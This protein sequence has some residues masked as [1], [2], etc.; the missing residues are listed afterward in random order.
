MRVEAVPSLRV[1][2]SWGRPRRQGPKGRTV[3]SACD[4]MITSVSA[5]N[6]LLEYSAIRELRVVLRCLTI[7]LLTLSVQGGLV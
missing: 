3:H 2:G 5:P 6:T 4:V 1:S 7:D